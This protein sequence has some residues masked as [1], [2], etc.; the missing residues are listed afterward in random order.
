MVVIAPDSTL[1][2]DFSVEIDGPDYLEDASEYEVF[3]IEKLPPVQKVKGTAALLTA[4]AGGGYYHWMFQVL[5]RLHL[6]EE[7]GIPLRD[8]DKFIVNLRVSR[9]QKETL[10]LLGIP[11]NKVIQSQWSPHIEAE[12]LVVATLPEEPPGWACTFIRDSFLKSELEAGKGSGI[13]R[14]YV[15][16]TGTNHRRIINEAEVAACLERYGFL[17]IQAE[18][19]SI[20]EQA[21]LMASAKIVVCPH[22]AGMSNIVFCNPGTKIIEMFSPLGVSPLFWGLA[23]VM[24]LEYYYLIGEGPRLP[25]HEPYR[26]HLKEDM[27]INISDLLAIMELAGVE[28]TTNPA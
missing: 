22:G 7:N 10:H 27:E 28:P 2:T 17:A 24:G 19:L 26:P 21:R 6:L 11:Q 3:T 16:R 23:N 25:K 20:V 13:E 5:P 8:V 18:K 9:F 14:L 4:P 1:L 15:C 12:E